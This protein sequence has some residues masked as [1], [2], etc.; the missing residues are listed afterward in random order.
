MHLRQRLP[1]HLRRPARRRLLHPRRPLHREGRLEARREGR[2]GARRGRVA[3]PLRRPRHGQQ[4]R[5]DREG[6]RRAQDEGRRRRLHLPQPSRLPGRR[7]LRAAPA[8]GPH[9]RRAAHPQARRVLAAA[10]PAHLPHRRAARRHE[11]PRGDDHRVRPPR[12]GSRWPR[13]RLVLLRQPRGARRPRARLPLQ[14]ARAHRADGTA[15]LRRAGDP[16]RGAPRPGQ[17]RPGARCAQAAAAARA[18]GDH[19]GP[20]VPA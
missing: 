17:G 19:R 11:L 15:R 14:R 12:L 18:P 20:A 9:R 13:P 8:R 4:G 16:R 2:R 10:D 7:R 6:G 5:L 3:V 1:G